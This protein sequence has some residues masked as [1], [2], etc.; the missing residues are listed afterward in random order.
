MNKSDILVIGAGMAGASAAYE[1]A[2]TRGVTV[3]ERESQPG[4]HTTGRS[5][6][7]FLETY[8]NATV[9]ALSRA[10][11]GFFFETPAGF[12]EQALL[13]KR[14]AMFIARADQLD[15]LKLFEDEVRR[16]T[17]SIVRLSAPEAREIVPV[18]KEGYVAAAVIEPESMDIDVHALHQG[19]LKGLR[20][21]GGKVVTGAE[22]TALSRSKGAWTLETPAGS[23]AA[24]VVV[25]AA[26]AWCD[27]IAEL[28]GVRPIGLVPKRRTAFTVEPP[29]GLDIS[30]WPLTID[31]D[32][33]FYF[34]PESGL[35]LLSPADQTPSPPCDARPEDIDVAIAVDRIQ[36]ATAL[37]VPR[38]AHRWAGLRSFV[39]DK[40]PVAGMD[41]DAEGFFWLAGQGGFGIQTAPAMGRAAAALIVSGAL[42]D[43]LRDQGLRASDLAPQRLR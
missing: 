30:A 40:S 38:I 2:E 8:G 19:Y 16:L 6:A 13:S 4:Y 20:Q 10:S 5:A 31:I 25:N 27:V 26:G 3:L 33:E 35:L 28:A 22:V 9:R 1:L 12:A 23:F 11:H 32:E 21:R 18:L 7:Q 42:P 41:D 14:A 24:P 29:P 34:K 39:A 37:T 36:T 17:P 15:A 43:D